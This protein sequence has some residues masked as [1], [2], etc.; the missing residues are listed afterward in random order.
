MKGLEI[1]MSSLKVEKPSVIMNS[2]FLII[3]HYKQ[4]IEQF[5]P[6]LHKKK[7]LEFY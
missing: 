5:H 7:K 1:S 3:E 4:T 2:I 6:N